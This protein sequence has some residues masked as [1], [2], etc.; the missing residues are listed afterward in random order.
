TKRIVVQDLVKGVKDLDERPLESLKVARSSAF[1]L[2]VSST[3]TSMREVKK[4][5]RGST[6]ISTKNQVT[7]PVDALRAAGLEAGQRVVASADGVGRVVLER[8][9]DVLAEFAGALT[10]IY[11]PGELDELRGEWA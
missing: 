10:G 4:R 11:Q 2:A 5:R 6:R 1:C 8:E 3:L 7:I 9:E